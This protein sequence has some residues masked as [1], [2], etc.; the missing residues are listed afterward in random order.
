MY[1]KKEKAV[2]KMTAAQRWEVGQIYPFDAL[3]ALQEDHDPS[4]RK[5]MYGSQTLNIALSNMD[6]PSTGSRGQ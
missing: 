1:R 3:Y 2:V 5:I 4:S 6:C